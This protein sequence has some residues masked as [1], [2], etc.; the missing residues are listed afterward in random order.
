ML[1][2][3]TPETTSPRKMTCP[4]QRWEQSVARSPRYRCPVSP[5]AKLKDLISDVAA[6]VQQLYLA[7]DWETCQSCEQPGSHFVLK[8]CAA[9]GVF[10]LRVLYCVSC[11]FSMHPKTVVLTESIRVVHA[12]R[13]SGRYTG[14]SVEMERSTVYGSCLGPLSTCKCG[15]TAG[16][17][18]Q[19]EWKD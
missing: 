3:A 15:E 12:N 7:R 17:T 18:R 14:S 1:D 8:K 6:R 13:E 9:C 19:N 2:F 5:S 4:I 10:G 16:G 11:G